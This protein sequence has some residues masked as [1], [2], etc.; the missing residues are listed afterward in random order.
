MKRLATAFAISVSLATGASAHGHHYRHYRY[1]HVVRAGNFSEGL[2]I[3]L[4]HM[5]DSAK[6]RAWCG[7]YMRQLLGVA[8]T[9]YNLAANWAHYGSPSFGPHVGAIVVW[10]HHVGIITGGQ[11]GAWVVKSGNDGNAVR[12]RPLSVARA[13]A[14]R[15][16]Y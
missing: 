5:M 15:E 7:Y 3:G 13:I 12:E 10:R 14:F 8:D 1:Q 16:R 6:P 4:M 9:S 11:P 2:G